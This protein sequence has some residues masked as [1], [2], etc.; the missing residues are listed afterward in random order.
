MAPWPGRC[1]VAVFLVVAVIAR[2]AS[3]DKI[4]IVSLVFTALL[5]TCCGML[6]A[7]VGDWRRRKREAGAD[8]AGDAT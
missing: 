1:A 7:N 2:A 3:G 4:E 8:A 5:G 6:G